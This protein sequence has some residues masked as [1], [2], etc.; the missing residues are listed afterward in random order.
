MATQ[1]ESDK[2]QDWENK[3][4]EREQSLRLREL[5]IEIMQG[6][7][8]SAP[9]T[10]SDPVTLEAQPK[11]S[12]FRRWIRRTGNILKFLSFFVVMVAVIRLGTWLAIMIVVGIGGWLGYK[13]FIEGDPQD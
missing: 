2:G 12:S 4:R 1:H 5:E 9:I 8:T 6:S 11:A 3:I 10:Q 13:A 7:S